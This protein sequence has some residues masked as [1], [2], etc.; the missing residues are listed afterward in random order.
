MATWISLHEAW[1]LGLAGIGAAILVINRVLRPGPTP[2]RAPYPET[3]NPGVGLPRPTLSQ[4]PGDRDRIGR[5][6][7]K[8]NRAARRRK[9]GSKVRE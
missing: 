7:A 3:R 1:L 4:R 9:G 5:G 8:Q 6:P 2:A